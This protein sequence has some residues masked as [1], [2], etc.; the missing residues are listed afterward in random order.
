MRFIQSGF[1][2]RQTYE[3][4]ESEESFGCPLHYS[5]QSSLDEMAK[6]RFSSYL[7]DI[8][9]TI[10]AYLQKLPYRNDKAFMNDFYASILLSIL[11]YVTM[12]M[13]ETQTHIDGG[14]LTEERTTQLVERRM[15]EN[16]VKYLT[17]FQLEKEYIDYFTVIFRQVKALVA[18]ELSQMLHT[19]I[20]Q[21]VAFSNMLYSETGETDEN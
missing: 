21:N 4:I 1:S 6:V 19:Y 18:N 5:M 10:K 12:T 11:N 9:K 17:L 20:P 2:D 14:H 16:E 7:G 15:E 8:P 3:P 13:E